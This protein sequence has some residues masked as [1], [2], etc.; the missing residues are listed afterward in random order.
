[1]EGHLA[2]G[3]LGFKSEELLENKCKPLKDIVKEV[4]AVVK[5]VEDK[6]NATIP[7]IAGGGVYTHQDICE[8]LDIGAQGVQIGTRF[9]ATNEC[10]ASDYFKQAYL[11]S[12][13]EEIRLL[14]SPAGLPARAVNTDFLVNADKVERIP[15]NKC[16]DCLTTCNPATTKYCISKALIDSVSG[17]DGLVFIGECGSRLNNITSVKELMDELSGID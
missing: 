15:V 12:T 17:R 6:Y 16:Y 4:R 9:V 13:P 5:E 3:H 10:D 7:I 1:M 2:G 14:A 11:N 8:L